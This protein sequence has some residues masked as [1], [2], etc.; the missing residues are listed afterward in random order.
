MSDLIQIKPGIDLLEKM[1]LI[2]YAIH[3]EITGDVGPFNASPNTRRSIALVLEDV[4]DYFTDLAARIDPLATEEIDGS[5]RWQA[6]RAVT[7]AATDE[8][9]AVRFALPPG[10]FEDALARA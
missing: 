7:S 3:C 10:A 1:S 2:E 5:T 4:A 9:P 6:V 8:P